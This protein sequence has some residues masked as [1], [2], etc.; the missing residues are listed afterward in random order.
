M[1]YEKYPMDNFRKLFT[2]Y[3]NNVHANKTVN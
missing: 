2:N 1:N 3:T